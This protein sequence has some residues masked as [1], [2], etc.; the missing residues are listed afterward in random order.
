MEGRRLS[1]PAIVGAV[2]LDNGVTKIEP[3]K[4]ESS[5]KHIYRKLGS[6][7][8]MAMFIC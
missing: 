8:C 7:A 4:Y 2:V 1:T 3:W 6:C 5:H